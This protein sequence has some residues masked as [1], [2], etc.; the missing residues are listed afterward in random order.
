MVT[1]AEA[2]FVGSATEVAVTETCAGLGTL[3]GAVYMP[4]P[5]MVPQDAPLQPLPPTAHETPVLVVPV[6]VAEN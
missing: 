5:E 6:T 1:T 4:L 2:F 3:D